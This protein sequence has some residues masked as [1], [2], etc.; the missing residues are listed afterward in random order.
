MA[1]E[2]PV[3][4]VYL[5]V[6]DEITSAAARIRAA[7]AGR[8]ALVLPYGS[9]L[10]TSRINFR[11]LAREAAERE[12]QVEIVC[13]D[14]SARALAA[15][16]G[17]PVHPSVAA[18]EGRAPSR[19]T[20]AADPGAGAALAGAGETL[21]PAPGGRA[22]EPPS[23]DDTPTRILPIPRR[24]SPKVPIV[25]PPRPPI[26]TGVAVGAG[27]AVILLLLVG[28]WLAMELLP[29][30]TIVLHPRSKEIGPVELTVEARTDVTAP[31]ASALVIPARRLAFELEATDTFTATGIKTTETKATGNVTFSNFDNRGGVVI[32]AGTV[33]RTD[34]KIAFVTVAE[35]S[36]PRAQ[37]DF[38]PPF[39]LHPS[40]GSVGVEAVVAGEGGN[41][42][43]NTIVDIPKGGRNLF[44]TNPDPTSGG[45][46]TE[47]PE[48]S[49]RDVDAAKTAIE[50]A[51]VGQLDQEVAAGTGVPAG[52]TVFADTRAVGEPVYAVDPA[53]LVGKAAT[54]FD[55][56]ATARGTALGVDPAPLGTIA[57]TRLRTRVTAGWT[58]VGDSITPLVG[59]PSVIGEVISYPVTVAGTQ[60]RD[61]DLAAL[62]ASIK[63]LLLAEARS[64]LDDYGDVQVTL[65]P[66]WVTTIPTRT[67]RITLSLGEPQ[68]SASPAP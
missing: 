11:L 52:V 56:S 10:A 3:S 12:K 21:A 22:G 4:L 1:G 8:V 49:Q 39:S 26:R 51:L 20:S 54:T 68:P 23:E 63:G 31:D 36:L 9:R 29:T 65:W 43:N 30:A 42:G 24:S 60:V 18:F 46:H 35:I 64:R 45:A 67:D 14:A 6:D 7:S 19:P 53:T 25:G 40:T 32:P 66:D 33:V 17:L 50:A 61:V 5:D 57:E 62:V 13:A 38:F 59:T 15:S 34:K 16:A 44:V 41:V 47:S 58:L 37:Y 27:I 2:T 48:V 55:L 28:G